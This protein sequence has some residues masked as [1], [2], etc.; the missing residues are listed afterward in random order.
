MK[1]RTK[2]VA[3]NHE[4]HYGTVTILKSRNGGIILPFPTTLM[5]EFRTRP[6]DTLTITPKKTGGFI[7]RFY[8][9]T[10]R[11]WRRLLPQGKSRPVRHPQ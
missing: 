3:T 5:E 6:G 8:R 10:R 9:Q 11:G 4:R 1:K 7:C 2:K